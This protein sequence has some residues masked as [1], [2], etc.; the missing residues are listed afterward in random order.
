MTC[1]FLELVSES[2]FQQVDRFFCGVFWILDS[3]I[4]VS[5]TFINLQN[6]RQVLEFWISESSWLMTYVLWSANFNQVFKIKNF[7]DFLTDEWH[8]SVC[9][10][11]DRCWK[12]EFLKVPDY[13]LTMFYD[14]Q[15]SIRCSSFRTSVTLWLVSDTHRSAK[16]S[17]GVVEFLKVPD[18]WLI[19]F[20]DLQTS[21]RCS[22]FRISVTF[23]L[24]SS[25]HQSA[26][27]STGV[28]S[29]T[30]E[31][32][33]LMTDHVLWSAL[34]SGVHVSELRW[35]S[36]CWAMFIHLQKSRQVLEFEVLKVSWL[37][38]DHVL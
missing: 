17:T 22:S 27:F 19:M 16:F 24:M 32:S 37:M 23:W 28:K 6:S 18:W 5:T 14:L 9:K 7:G 3:N 8:S 34:Q 21:I 11:L 33:W 31:S 29:W 26:K 35:L 25:V 4:S 13:W 30:S 38:T 20:C 10:V 36:D 12:F 2:N 1:W 15:I